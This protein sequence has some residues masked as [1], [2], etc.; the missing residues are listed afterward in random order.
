MVVGNGLVAKRFERYKGD[1]NFLVFASGVSNSKNVIKEEYDREFHLLKETLANNINK[2]LVYF[3]TCS[4]YDPAEQNSLYVNF[5]KDIEHYITNNVERYTI[6]RGSNLVGLSQNPNTILNFFSHHIEQGINFSLWMNA[7]RN[8]I[9]IDDFFAIADYI[10]Q[11]NIYHNSTVNI[12]NPY[13]Y[14][15]VEI[16][17]AIQA[18]YNIRATYMPVDKGEPFAINVDDTLPIIRQLDIKFGESYLFNM[19]RKY[20]T[21]EL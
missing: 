15:V 13:S 6:F 19:L 12:A 16:V 21:H 11:E 9:D 20:Y 8:L 10:L 4:I 7:T 2:K 18:F 5:K 17:N 3:S 1:D 14:K